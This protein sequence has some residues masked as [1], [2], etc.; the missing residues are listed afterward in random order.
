MKLLID[1]SHLMYRVLYVS[2]S[3]IEKASKTSLEQL[4]GKKLEP[5][6]YIFF[7]RLCNSI[8]YLK[9]KFK[10]KAKDMIFFEDKSS[11]RK[12]IYTE[13]K[14]KRKKKKEEDN[15]DWDKFFED[16]QKFNEKFFKYTDMT[17][18]T[19]PNDFSFEADDSM[20]YFA[21]YFSEKG[22][23]S[24]IVTS[25]KDLQQ[26]LIYD[27]VYVYNPI[28]DKLK[29]KGK[30]PEPDIDIMKLNEEAITSLF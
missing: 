24:T 15:F 17:L 25:D 3:N 26:T 21:K 19:P 27:K 11:W 14:A 6:Q 12:K 7:D 23:E 9:K 8:L 5:Y 20:Y 18:I 4:K 10:V 16:L 2:R 28:L 29:T 30:P 22:I 1:Y 13:F